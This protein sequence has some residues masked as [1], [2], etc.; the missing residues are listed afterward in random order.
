MQGKHNPMQRDA[1]GLGV[2]ATQLAAI[3]QGTPA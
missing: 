3:T 2:D 1:A